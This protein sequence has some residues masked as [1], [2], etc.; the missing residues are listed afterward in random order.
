MG[1]FR[2]AVR[3]VRLLVSDGHKYITE[4]AQAFVD[5]ASLQRVAPG[6]A[7]GNIHVHAPQKA[8]QRV[9][10]PRDQ[11]CVNPPTIVFIHF[12]KDNFHFVL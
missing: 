7:L 10:P 9:L 12:Y 3:D 5:C 6:T 8:F 4:A 2:V 1:E 11:A